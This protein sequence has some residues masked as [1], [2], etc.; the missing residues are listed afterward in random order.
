MATERA[1]SGETAS[2]DETASA[3]PYTLVPGE[4]AA[5]LTGHPWRRFVAVGD[6]IAEGVGDPMPGYDRAGWV[7]QVAAALRTVRPD[8]AYLNLGQSDLR[9]A[10]VRERQLAR[11]L[12]FEPDLA[13]VACGGND[14]LRPR[15]EPEVASREVAAIIEP[16]QQ[17]GADVMTISVVVVSYYPAF[18]DWFR[19]TASERMRMLAEHTNALA[20]KLG[21]LHVDL[22]DHPTGRLPYHELLSR[23]GLHANARSHAVCAAEAIRRLGAHL[24]NVGR[25]SR[26][27]G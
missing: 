1:S 23:D 19:P 21:T 20:A 7:D 11:A 13:L 14:A 22:A 9:A 2:T 12:A 26:R 6:S 10:Q 24:G 3:D 5:L 18:P 16:L 8:L 15:Y 27:P 4:A 25:V 17:A